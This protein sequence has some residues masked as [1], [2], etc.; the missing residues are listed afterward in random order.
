MSILDSISLTIL[1]VT[2][3]VAFTSFEAVLW[4]VH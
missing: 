4:T 1:F 2:I 3:P